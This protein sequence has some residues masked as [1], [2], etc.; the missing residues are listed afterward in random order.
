MDRLLACEPIRIGSV[1]LLPIERVTLRTQA[2]AT[3]ALLTASKQPVALVVRDSCG[4]RAI[5]FGA[6]L[7]I[8][9]MRAQIPELD[10]LF[11]PD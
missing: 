5:H 4:I 10:D 6:E 8:E 1:T 3:H 7:S 2:T 11:A 9:Q